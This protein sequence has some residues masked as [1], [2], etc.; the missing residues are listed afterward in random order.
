MPHLH[1]ATPLLDIAYETSGPAHGSP[2]LLLH[3]WPDDVRTY[4]GIVPA[5][6]DAGFRAIVPWLRGFGP[7]RFRSAATPRSGQM[8]A[9]A[10]DALDLLDALGLERVAVVGHDWGA[11]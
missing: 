1:T 11:R 10:R 3:G 5:L 8:V 2:V 9:F 4:D 6:H 7:T